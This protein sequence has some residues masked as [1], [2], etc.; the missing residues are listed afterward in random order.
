MLAECKDHGYFRGETCPECGDKGR[1]LMNDQELDRVGRIMAGI[2]R[3]FPDRF[4][5]TM[6]SYG[7]VDMRD[8]V[9]AVRDSKNRLHW[10][11]P[12]HIEAIA[13]TDE[14]GRYQVDGGMVR[15]T[16]GH[17]LDVVLDDLPL[18]QVEELF[19]PVSEE[20]Q[21]IVL[22]AGLHPTDR[23]KLHL[24]GSYASAHEAGRVRIEEPIILRIDAKAAVTNGVDIRRAGKQVY[25]AEDIGPEYLEVAEEPEDFQV[26]ETVEVE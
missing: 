24:S 8:M 17:S 9:D 12:H 16:Y 3:H 15:A 19:Y 20:E 23:K 2:L 22:E 6:D 1:F 18:C 25:I 13:D 26:P 7:W 21:D 14:K 5:L 4:D 11:R 10:L